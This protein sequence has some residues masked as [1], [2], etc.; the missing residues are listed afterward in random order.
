MIQNADIIFV[1][2]RLDPVSTKLMQKDTAAKM[3]PTV[4]LHMGH[5]T[6]E[7]LFMISGSISISI[8]IGKN[9]Q[10]LVLCVCDY[11]S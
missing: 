2:I 7:A 8:L 10:T 11:Q 9:S 4:P 3:A 5:M 1:T 6:C